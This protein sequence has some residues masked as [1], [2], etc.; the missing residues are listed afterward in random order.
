MRILA[1]N[2]EGELGHIGLG[3]G[4]GAGRAQ[5]PHHRGVGFGPRRIREHLRPGAGRLAGDVEQVLDA[6][7]GAIERSERHASTC[8]SIGSIGSSMGADSG[9]C[10][11]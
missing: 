10:G 8:A 3:D 6:D 2:G 9:E 7:D 11:Q 5:P 4:N 1:E